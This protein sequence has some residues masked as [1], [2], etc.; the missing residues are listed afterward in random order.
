MWAVGQSRTGE[1]GS[2][3]LLFEVDGGREGGGTGGEG[4]G[5]WCAGM[6]S[7]WRGVQCQWRRSGGSDGAS[8]VVSRLAGA[9]GIRVTTL[10]TVRL[11]HHQGYIRFGWNGCP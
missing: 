11:V 9:W 5:G 10:I 3:G 2:M 6:E 7:G 8:A 4:G 1:I